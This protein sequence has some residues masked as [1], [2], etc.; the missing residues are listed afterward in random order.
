ML[1]RLIMTVFLLIVF[2]MPAWANEQQPKVSDTVKQLMDAGIDLYEEEILDSID[3]KTEDWIEGDTYYIRCTFENPTNTPLQKKVA[4]TAVTYD[5]CHKDDP[6]QS[7]T[8]C[9]DAISELSLEPKATYTTTIALKQPMPVQFNHLNA[10]TFVFEDNASLRYVTLSESAPSSAFHLIPIVSPFGEVTLKLQNNSP[11]QTIT[12]LRDIRLHFTIGEESRKMLMTEPISLQIKPDE[13][14]T[15]PLFTLASASSAS[16]SSP[17]S[18]SAKTVNT[19]RSYSCHINMKING[20]PHTYSVSNT[21]ATQVANATKRTQTDQAD[22]YYQFAPKKL[23]PENGAFYLDGS[24]LCGYIK[25]KN[26]TDTTVTSSQITYQLTLPYFDTNS[27]YHEVHYIVHLPQSL[28]LDA[29]KS[30]NYAFKLPLPAGLSKL[31]TQ[32]VITAE[33]TNRALSKVKLVQA[34]NAS[35]IPKKDYTI[36]NH[37]EIKK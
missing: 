4:Y 14:Y 24:N 9:T 10:C 33:A 27:Q 20:I 28:T 5:L 32:G 22:T 17:F 1:L 19:T 29:K 35:D 30:A 31:H 2:A 16:S 36:L 11:T 15:M 21:D 34:A 13:S 3:I 8:Q 23:D 18:L 37:I 12:E 6:Y 26:T 7:I 25:V